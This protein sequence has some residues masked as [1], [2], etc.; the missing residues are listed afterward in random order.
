MKSLLL[1]GS[2]FSGVSSQRFPEAT[3]EFTGQSVL[4]REPYNKVLQAESAY[5]VHF[6]IE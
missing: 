2:L 4:K 5:K 3:Y 1:N 6:H